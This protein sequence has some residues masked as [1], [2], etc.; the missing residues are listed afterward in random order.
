MHKRIAEIFISRITPGV[1]NVYSIFLIAEI[2]GA[3]EYGIFSTALA[4][5]GLL[6]NLLFGPFKNAIIPEYARKSTSSASAYEG[7]LLFVLIM[8]GVALIFLGFG[9]YYTAGVF[10]FYCCML[11]LIIGLYDTWQSILR[12]RINFLLYGVVSNTQAI[13]LV[14]MLF[15][16]THPNIDV[17]LQFYIF[18]YGVGFLL[19]FVLVR[20]FRPIMPEWKSIYDTLRLGG[21]LTLGTIGESAI[22]LGFRYALMYFGAN[23]FLG[24]YS[25]AIDLAQR[26][27]GIVISMT[28]FSV[29]PRAYKGLV[30]KSFSDF[31]NILYSGARVSLLLS[32]IL[33]CVMPYAIGFVEYYG[34]GKTDMFVTSYFVSASVAVIVNRLRKLIVDPVLISCHGYSRI[35][36]SYTLML[37]LLYL[38]VWVGL[39]YESSVLLLIVY[40]SVYFFA[41]ICGF[42]YIRLGQV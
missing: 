36:Y 11:V 17:V 5:C 38:G 42:R 1:L 10:V 18:S 6:S 14:L 39:Y 4:T 22:Y 19:C 3:S 31:K 26:T 15:I 20:C 2:L 29:L 35:F 9:I 16:Y 37:P 41:A 30:D 27:I 28:S 12:A 33:V 34:L 24:L 8:V 40:P 21:W 25:F 32:V 13:F 23:S 7:Q